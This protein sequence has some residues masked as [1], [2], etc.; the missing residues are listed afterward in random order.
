ME[1]Y[2]VNPNVTVRLP[3]RPDPAT[4]RK[5]VRRKSVSE[6]EQIRSL[7]KWMRILIWI[8]AGA[9]AIIIAL[10]IPAVNYLLE[11]SQSLRPGQNYSS[12]V[13]AS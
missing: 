5:S 10:S 3:R 7:K 6:E 9:L 13:D 2:P 12:A 1:K 11:D 8:L 4:V